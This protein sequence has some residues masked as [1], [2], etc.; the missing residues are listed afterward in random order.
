MD[1]IELR[2]CFETRVHLVLD[3]LG[4]LRSYATLAGAGS[5][6]GLRLNVGSVL[7]GQQF[8]NDPEYRFG[9]LQ[10]EISEALKIASLSGLRITG[11]H[12]YF[13]TDILDP[14]LLLAGVRRLAALAE[15]F[16]HLEYIDLAGGLG[17]G[18]GAENHEFNLGSYG[19]SVRQVL[20]EQERRIG[21]PLQAWLEPG[22][23]LA[24]SC[25]FFFVTVIDVK[26]RPDRV[27]VGTNGSV[28]IFPRPLIY[29]DRARHPCELI[30]PAG[31]REMSSKPVYVC[32]NS[33][34]S[35]DFLARDIQLQMPRIGDRL[36]FHQAGAYCR[37]MITS[38]LGKDAP[39]E[40][41]CRTACGIGAETRRVAEI[42]AHG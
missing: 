12:S 38:F 22:R 29:P 8:K 20:S 11:I 27:F 7:D 19:Q 10:G 30:A 31:Q 14:K 2:K 21:R 18:E 16:P 33:T 6:V 36:A 15:R 41:V 42:P 32:G 28:S 37:S 13:G 39:S 40:V 4:Q 9:L 24:A 23:Y 35:R 26:I 17:V 5:A 34:Y 1:E 3:S 25:G